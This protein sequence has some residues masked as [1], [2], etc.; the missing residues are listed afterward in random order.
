MKSIVKPALF[1]V[2]ATCAGHAFAADSQD[3]WK[4]GIG[5]G[6]SVL[7][8]KG[9][10]GFNSLLVGPVQVSMNLTPNDI[11]NAAKSAFGFG[12]FAAKD[13]WKILYSLKYLELQGDVNGVT[14]GGVPISGR[15]NFK[16][17]GGDVDGVYEFARSE[18]AAWG[19]LGGLRYTKHK[20]SNSLTIGASTRAN[21]FSHSWTDV[22]IGLTN[23]FYFSKEWAWNTRVDA[24]FGGS[25]GTYHGNTGVSWKF[26]ESW[27]TGATIDYIANNFETGTK[28]NSDW[29]LYK[30][31]EASAGINIMYL[32]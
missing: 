26:A 30:G 19:A 29:Y 11:N 13:K 3:E 31:R 12:G 27:T 2:A 6:I 23:S 32:F 22:V 21:D 4:F 28:G 16:V 14:P 17:S 1:I 10:L 18:R 20:F 7:D 8:V 9:P 24:G 5:T 15:S 25:N